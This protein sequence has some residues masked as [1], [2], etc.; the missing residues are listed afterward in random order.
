MKRLIINADDFGL[1]LSVNKA[2]IEAHQKGCLTSTSI[3]PSGKAFDHAVLLALKNPGL[4]IG[5]HLTLVAEAPVSNPDCIPSLVTSTKVFNT[6]YPQFLLNYI[7]GK[8][9]LDEVRLELF[10]QVEKVVNTGIK[11][12]HLDS[13][14]HLHVLPGILD[15]VIEIA[16]KYNIKAIRIPDESYLFLGGYPFKPFRMIARAGLTFLAKRARTKISKYG[17]NTPNNFF[18]ML[19][20]GNMQEKYLANIIRQLP[21]GISEIMVHPAIDGK[22]LQR[23]LKWSYNWE[24]ELFALT[25]KTVIKLINKDDIRLVSFGELKH[26]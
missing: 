12:T 13:H 5:I 9:N 21:E 1:H 26:D 8:I 10:A 11:V 19:A 18:G 7:L 24:D 20:G 25:S 2:V 23:L 14:Q 16:K 22:V 3:I 15:I 17:L 6:Q 4:G